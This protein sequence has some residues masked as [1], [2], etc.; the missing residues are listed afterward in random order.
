VSRLP[1]KK[2]K[3]ARVGPGG[4]APL[5]RVSRSFEPAFAGGGLP[6]SSALPL[7][8]RIP[9]RARPPII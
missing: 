9:S 5:S 4:W 6:F 8:Y 7:G 1:N 3:A 2:T